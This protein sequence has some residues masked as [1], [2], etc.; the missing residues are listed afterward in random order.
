MKKLIL[1]II[2]VAMSFADDP[3]SAGYYQKTD[4]FSPGYVQDRDPF[5]PGYVQDKTIFGFSKD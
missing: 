1:L 5:S 4:P 2:L 3:F